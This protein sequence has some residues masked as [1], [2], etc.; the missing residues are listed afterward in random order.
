MNTAHSFTTEL[1]LRQSGSYRCMSEVEL[2]KGRPITLRKSKKEG[3]GNQSI[4]H[5]NHLKIYI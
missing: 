5:L 2:L 1:N 3:R 4:N